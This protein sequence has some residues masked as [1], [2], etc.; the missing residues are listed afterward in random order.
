MLADMPTV[1]AAFEAI[2]RKVL[3]DADKARGDINLSRKSFAS[4]AARVCAP[5]PSA[6]AGS[7]LA[8]SCSAIDLTDHGES[9]DDMNSVA[10]L[11]QRVHELEAKLAACQSFEGGFRAAVLE[12][13]QVPAALEKLYLFGSPKNS[14]W[15]WSADGLAR[16]LAPIFTIDVPS[17]REVLL[18]HNAHIQRYL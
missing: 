7:G 2:V 17:M 15:E 6:R 13:P 3:Q 16:E 1:V 11:Q 14:P 10:R 18:A 5:P 8:R 4:A 12:H 9:D